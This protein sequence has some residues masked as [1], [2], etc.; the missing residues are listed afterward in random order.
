MQTW[1]RFEYGTEAKFDLNWEP[2]L[3]AHQINRNRGLSSNQ[4][5]I[6]RFNFIVIFSIIFERWD[7]CPLCLTR[8][9]L[10]KHFSSMKILNL[11]VA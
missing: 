6:N 2:H 5:I 7:S 3:F 1:I 10:I 11:T 9:P 8:K 4:Y